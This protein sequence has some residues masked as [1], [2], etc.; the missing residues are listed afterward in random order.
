MVLI[1][2]SRIKFILL[3][4]N[5]KQAPAWMTEPVLWLCSVFLDDSMLLKY[6][7]DGQTK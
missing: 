2:T 4:L 3:A 7:S 6:V 1:F 5:I